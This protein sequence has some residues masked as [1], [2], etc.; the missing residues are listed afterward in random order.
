VFELSQNGIPIPPTFS[1]SQTKNNDTEFHKKLA[2]IT[3]SGRS[4]NYM[5]IKVFEKL[6]TSLNHNE[7]TSSDKILDRI[8]NR[9][10]KSPKEVGMLQ[11]ASFDTE[12]YF[13]LLTPEGRFQ[14]YKIDKGE[15]EIASVI[16]N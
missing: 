13:F 12:T 2:T 11:I 14:H 5:R 7:Y 4:Y 1:D 16:F 10:S 8:I 3:H 15:D 9:L 6:F